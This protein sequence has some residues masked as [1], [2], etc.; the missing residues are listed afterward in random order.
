MSAERKLPPDKVWDSVMEMVRDDEARRLEGLSDE[1][2]EREIASMGRDPRAERA[3]GANGPAPVAALPS[4]R[5]HALRCWLVAAA[6][7][8]ALVA[9]FVERREFIAWIKG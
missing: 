8:A 5:R 6:F 9:L 7:L 2:L 4:A 1:E 3:K